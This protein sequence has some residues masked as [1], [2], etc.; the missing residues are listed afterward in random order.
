MQWECRKIRRYSFFVEQVLG[1]VLGLSSN[2]K[3]AKDSPN[4]TFDKIKSIFALNAIVLVA[5]IILGILGFG[6]SSYGDGGE[7]STGYRGFFM[8]LMSCLELYW[9]CLALFCFIQK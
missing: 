8:Q 5:N 9:S 1:G 6:Y 3:I 7:D 2:G 4:F